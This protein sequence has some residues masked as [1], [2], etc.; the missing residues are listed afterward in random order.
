M[1]AFLDA[2]RMN[3]LPDVLDDHAIFHFPG[4]SRFAGTYTGK[5]TIGRF[6]EDHGQELM[7]PPDCITVDEYVLSPNTITLLA[8]MQAQRESFH[9]LWKCTFLLSIA[10]EC[11]TEWW[12]E[13][14]DVQTFDT[15]WSFRTVLS[16]S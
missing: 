12:C 3:T 7:T 14:D 8:T 1:V 13:L 5:K 6:W 16:T 15:F 2:L 11:I 4:R 9:H 10:H